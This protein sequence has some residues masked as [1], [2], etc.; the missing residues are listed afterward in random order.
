MIWRVGVLFLNSDG[1]TR[2][3][4]GRRGRSAD[5]GPG[6]AS[7]RSPGRDP[8]PERRGKRRFPF[9]RA[10]GGP[11]NSLDRVAKRPG[12]PRGTRPDGE[13]RLTRRLPRF[14]L[15]DERVVRATPG[16]QPDSL[17]T[18]SLIF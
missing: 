11:G 13:P 15:P 8:A 3:G 14:L 7:A 6:A 5:V 2:A 18:T 4:R 12:A 17:A 1:E 9:H 10:R 16:H